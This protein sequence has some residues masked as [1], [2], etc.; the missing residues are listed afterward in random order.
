MSA[1]PAPFPWDAVLGYCL[2][3]LRWPPESFWRATP[4]E[5]AAALGDVAASAPPTRAELATLMCAHPDAPAC[6]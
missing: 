6:G 3:R 2:T 4:R 5:L 1:A